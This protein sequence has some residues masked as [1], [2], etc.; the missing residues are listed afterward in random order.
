MSLSLNT[1][2]V[3]VVFFPMFTCAGPLLF[4]FWTK[5]GEFF[6]TKKRTHNDLQMEKYRTFRFVSWNVFVYNFNI[7]KRKHEKSKIVKKN[8]N[9]KKEPKK[10]SHWFQIIT[11]PAVNISSAKTK[12]GESERKKFGTFLITFI[13]NTRSSALL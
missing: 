10:N 4:S 8:E 6:S 13:Q 11:F 2:L 5:T 9:V 3:F 12:N 7:K 1:L